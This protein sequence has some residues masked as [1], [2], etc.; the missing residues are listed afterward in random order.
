MRSASLF[1]LMI[2]RP[3]RSTLFPYTTLFRS[4]RVGRAPGELGGSIQR[5]DVGGIA[6]QYSLDLAARLRLPP[7]QLVHFGEHQRGI[8]VGRIERRRPAEL[9]LGLAIATFPQVDEPEVG[10][11]HG[12]VGGKL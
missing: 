10:I 11:A 7:G 5:P 12:L 2:R 8:V 1:F 4:L 9:G 6:A 3:P